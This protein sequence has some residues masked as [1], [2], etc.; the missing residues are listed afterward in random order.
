MASRPPPPRPSL[1]RDQQF[2]Q[3]SI[4]A[5]ANHRSESLA[6]IVARLSGSSDIEE[7]QKTRDEIRQRLNTADEALASQIDAHHDSFYDALNAFQQVTAQMDDSKVKVDML[8]RGLRDCKKLLR[9]KREQVHRLWFESIEYAEMLKLLDRIE[10]ITQ[11]PDKVDALMEARQH[12]EAATLLVETAD[13]LEGQSLGTV[14]ALH[15]LHRQLV[16]RMQEMQKVIVKELQNHI[17]LKGAIDSNDIQI[18]ASVS[19]SGDSISKQ[20]SNA[21]DD[22]FLYLSLGVEALAVLK[23]IPQLI[24][25]LRSTLRA[26]LS[27]LID[28]A[29]AIAN[30]TFGWKYTDKTVTGDETDGPTI[31]SNAGPSRLLRF[32]TYLYERI[33]RVFIC[34]CNVIAAIRR[35][36]GGEQA[37]KEANT[38]GNNYSGES[39]WSSIQL[40]LE[41]FLCQYLNVDPN[42]VLSSYRAGTSAINTST[43]SGPEEPEQNLLFSFANSLNTMAET[44]AKAERAINDGVAGSSLMGE[45]KT[46]GYRGGSA[47]EATVNLLCPKSPYN[48][49]GIFKPTVLFVAEMEAGLMQSNAASGSYSLFDRRATLPVTLEDFVG[50]FIRS[51]FILSVKRKTHSDFKK[52]AETADKALD[53]HGIPGAPRILFKSAK[54][55]HE[56]MGLLCGYI[57]DLPL[58]AHDFAALLVVVLTK[59]HRASQYKYKSYVKSKKGLKEHICMSASLEATP[60][61]QSLIKDGKDWI[62]LFKI[63]DKLSTDKSSDTVPV[64]SDKS[65][66]TAMF[67]NVIGDRVPSKSD[68][69]S[70]AQKVKSIAYL[71][72]SLH[73]FSGQV[74]WASRCLK[75][76]NGT[77]VSKVWRYQGPVVSD[78]FE[79]EDRVE[80]PSLQMND[81]FKEQG[82]KLAGLAADYSYLAESCLMA[83]RLELR[84]RCLHFLLPVLRSS[85]YT[86]TAEQI[87]EADPQVVSLCKDILMYDETLSVALQPLKYQIVFADLGD[88]L[89]TLLIRNIV[90]IKRV[91]HMGVKRMCRSIFAL[92]QTLRTINRPQ[93]A[94]IVDNAMA[95]FELLTLQPEQVLEQIVTFGKV[96][97]EAEY[98]NVLN[99]IEASQNV[100]DEAAHE[101]VLKQLREVF[102][103][104]V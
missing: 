98:R 19:D 60:Q 43:P 15:D 30:K 37:L 8:R 5:P 68:I 1:P 72:E 95:Y 49:T 100:A 75:T 82:I 79:D 96:Y 58:V 14:R 10:E 24:E 93:C 83:L 9:L 39:V 54:H 67:L 80:L 76:N 25:S 28:K 45:D 85:S 64:M 65:V 2:K 23:N 38:S 47:S 29:V 6:D 16:D 31:R 27:L 99:L 3:S 55:I 17:Y 56:I 48:I 53:D 102:H 90:H 103:E 26:E 40:E 89:S 63:E 18:S 73:W 21:D 81:G 51:N 97:S 71:H 32:L 59:F 77:E 42:A 13:A 35:S 69:I 101:D 50:T 74:H 84:V 62:G 34:H 70:D 61:I 20:T 88:F 78:L 22:P 104:L 66:E 12:V 87:E 86:C 33:F 94:N 41:L 57:L 44:A 91:N 46:S 4:K 36:P 52:I 92:Q 7:R 11:V